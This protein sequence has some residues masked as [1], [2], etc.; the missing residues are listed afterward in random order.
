MNDHELER[1]LDELKA[2]LLVPEPVPLGL[3]ARLQAGVARGTRAAAGV[4]WET[5]V[6][7]AC[8]AFLV[9]WATAGVQGTI[10]FALVAAVVVAAYAIVVGPGDADLP[11]G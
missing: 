9:A 11:S 10:A 2:T 8:L 3:T 6:V 7:V 4:G 1:Q 5:R